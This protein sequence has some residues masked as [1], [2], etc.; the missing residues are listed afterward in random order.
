MIGEHGGA[1][2]ISCESVRSSERVRA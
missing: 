2:K 1:I